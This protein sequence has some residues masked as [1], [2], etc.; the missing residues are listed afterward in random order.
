MRHIRQ[1]NE[2]DCG[3]AVAAM[4][5]GKKW[6]DA[7]DADTH[8]TKADGLT[9][10]EFLVMCSALGSRIGMIKASGKMHLKN[11]TPPDRCCGMLIHRFGARVGHYVAFDGKY[12]YDPDCKRRVRWSSYRR[13]PW[14]ICRWFVAC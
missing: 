4:I 12:V 5:C 8:P 9:T 2:F 1:Y 10:K 14:K 6:Q 11:A 7:A 13:R 3:L